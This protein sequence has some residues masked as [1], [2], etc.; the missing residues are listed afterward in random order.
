MHS[1][2]RDE[3]PLTSVTLQILDNSKKIV[4]QKTVSKEFPG[5]VLAISIPFDSPRRDFW[6]QVV[7][8]WKN[9]SG[10]QTKISEIHYTCDTFQSSPA[11][12]KA[13]FQSA[14]STLT[15]SAVN[16]CGETIRTG[17]YIESI[18]IISESGE[19]VKEQ[20]N[21]PS[22][23]RDVTMTDLPA[24]NYIAQVKSGDFE[25]EVP[26]VLVGSA[27]KGKRGQNF[28]MIIAIICMIILFA[29]ALVYMKRKRKHL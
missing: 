10:D 17:G 6:V 2:G 19:T 11:D 27:S 24:G 7:A 3:T 20:Y 22:I 12:L 5:E 16:V 28:W 14:S 29:L 13:L 26:F 23:T 8:R 18:R 4:T 25:R 21:I 1:P 9:E 15:I